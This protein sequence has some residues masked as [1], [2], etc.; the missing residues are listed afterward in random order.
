ME[1]ALTGAAG[2]YYIAFRLSAL[3]YAIGLT[4]RGTRA[5]DLLASNP[6]K[7]KTIIIQIKTMMRAFVENR[8]SG[9]YWHWRI[10]S[11]RLKPQD[12]FY[13]A[14]VDLKG[15]PAESPD[16]FIIPSLEIKPE[17]LAEYTNYTGVCIYETDKGTVKAYLN[18]WDIVQEALGDTRT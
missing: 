10:G 12:I 2:E 11:S 7:G 3:G 13:Y 18:R 5:A 1:K 4:P 9:S 16:V 15:N 17:L 8:K 14:F 6:E